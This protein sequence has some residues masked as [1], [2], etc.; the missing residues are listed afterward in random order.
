MID[1]ITEKLDLSSEPAPIR[2]WRRLL[3]LIIALVIIAAGIAGA[4]YLKKSAPKTQK[5]PPVKWVPA[6]QVESLQPTRYQVMVSAMGTVIPARQ[7]VLKSQVSGQ[8]QW[9][10]PEFTEGGFLK[11]GDLIIQLDDADYQLALA[12][13]KKD[14]ADSRYAFK[15]EL[16]HQEVAR[17]EWKLLSGRHTGMGPESE[18]ALRKPH[19]EKVKAE[20]AAAE[21]LVEKANLDLKRTRI[22]APFNAM[23]RSKSVDIGSQ[24]SLQ[25]PLADLVGTDVYWVQASIPVERLS[26]IHIPLRAGELGALAKIYYVRDHTID[27]RVFRLMGDLSGE[28]RMARI[29]IEVKDPVRHQ[30]GNETDP[31]LLIGEYVRLEIEG[32][33][34]E[35]VY[36][37]S[38]TTLRDEDTVWLVN[39]DMTLAIRKVTPVW[40]GEENVVIQDDLKAGDRII[41]SD[42]PAPVAGMDVRVIGAET[43]S[44]KTSASVDSEK[45]QHANYE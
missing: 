20:M 23:V 3:R 33:S 30:G 29:L 19:L 39:A 27:G 25:N 7:I 41:V 6:V 10:H 35:N 18:L 42:L 17:R 31:P 15:I 12:Q 45:G 9:I 5:K 4:A 26:W 32:R 11:K 21:A 28:G 14:L 24:V 34:L 13:K 43:L 22:T 37:V 36:V 38:R 40:R 2:W 8:I 44:G 16:G 1:K